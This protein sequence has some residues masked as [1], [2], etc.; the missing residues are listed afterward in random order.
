[1]GFVITVGYNQYIIFT[2]VAVS[3]MLHQVYFQVSVVPLGTAVYH[4]KSIEAHESRCHL[5]EVHIYSSQHSHSLQF[6][7]FDFTL[8]ILISSCMM[9]SS[10]GHLKSKGIGCCS[11]IVFLANKH[12]DLR[13]SG[14][15]FC[16]HCSH[17]KQ[18]RNSQSKD[19]QF[20]SQLNTKSDFNQPVFT[21]RRYALHGI[22]DSN[23]VCLSVRLSVCLSHSWTVFTWFDLRL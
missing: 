4:V 12:N 2:V 11:E 15:I 14:C 18:L 19:S 6:V 17:S 23:S 13:P 1:M 16:H 3:D 5:A 20:E 21:V 8:N 7:L 10:V 9:S 22:C